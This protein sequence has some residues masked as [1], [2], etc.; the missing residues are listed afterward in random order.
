MAWL[1][2]N[3]PGLALGAVV[4]AAVL[5][6]SSG[7]VGLAWDDGV[8]VAAG[9]AL[10]HGRGYILANRIGDQAVPLYPAGYPLL[11]SLAWLVAGTQSATFAVLA[12][13]SGLCVSAA[14]FLWWRLLR[15]ALSPGTAVL[16]VAVPALSYAT[17]LTGE[18]RM[19]DAPYVLLVAAAAALWRQSLESR[20]T[21]LALVLVAAAALPL[22]TAG[23][24]LP[25][26][27]ALLLLVRRRW[28]PALAVVLLVGALQILLAG[29]LRS[30]EP[31]YAEI[32]RAAWAQGG[33]GLD[34][35]RA[36][37][38]GD[39][40]TSIAAL[41]AP[42]L[43]YSSVV[44]RLAQGAAAL[45]LLYVLAIWFVCLAV[46]AGGWRRLR[47]ERWEVGDLTFVGAV[48]LIFVMP[49]GMLPR[50]LVPVGPVLALWAWEGAGSL[51]ARWARGARVV[52]LVVLALTAV[53]AVRHV[54]NQPKVFRDRA[55]A[56][57]AAGGAARG[58]LGRSGLIAA[59]FPETLWFED[60]LRA[61]STT[62]PLENVQT[63]RAGLEAARQRL[64]PVARGCLLDTRSFP[65]SRELFEAY[66]APPG[67]V[68]LGGPDARYVRVVCWG[69]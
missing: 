57:A 32:V 11:V 47:A 25:L 33:A 12:V 53:E 22:R 58:W 69:R 36:N 16:L 61:V 52:L 59:E 38:G 3:W 45:R 35:L 19:A 43:V 55:A 62:T 21:M 68:V 41:V 9:Q 48:A 23:A 67:A 18:L 26:A 46:A 15:D 37:L 49:L 44:Q 8:Y 13:L 40:W 42:P 39:L 66:A 7:V 29:L 63:A 24:V 56:Y 2:A 14:A 10:A 30:P 28:V 50:F 60:G 65:V 54:R 27:V 6:A 5:A 64:L 1:R 4:L 17:L 31:S 20:W 34:I 51:G